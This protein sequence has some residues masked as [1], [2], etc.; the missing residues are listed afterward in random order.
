MKKEM[1]RALQRVADVL[2]G[3]FTVCFQNELRF[4][5]LIF[6]VSIIDF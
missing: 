1:L 4:M 2:I 5:V 3:N 6:I